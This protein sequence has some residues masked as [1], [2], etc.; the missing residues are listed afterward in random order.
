MVGGKKIISRTVCRR[1]IEA[2]TLS[3][4]TAGSQTRG[5]KKRKK[6]NF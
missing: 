4:S 1:K 5:K 3:M 2:N 6:S